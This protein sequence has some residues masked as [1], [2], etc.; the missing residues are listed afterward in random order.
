[1][2]SASP[3]FKSALGVSHRKV[4]TI[5]VNTPDG[6]EHELQWA[7]ASVSSSNSTGVRYSANVDVIPDP[8]VDLYSIISTPG[9]LFTIRHGIDFGDGL[10]ELLP[11][12]VYEAASGG[13]DIIDGSIGLSLVDQWQRVE[14]C[15]FSKPFSSGATG[16]GRGEIIRRVIADIT[17]GNNPGAIPG[18]E[19][20]IRDQGGTATLVGRVWDKDRT[21]FIKDMATDGELEYYFDASGVFVVR[22]QPIIDPAASVWTFQTGGA[23]NIITA[24]RERPFDRLYNRVVIRPTVEDQDWPAVVVDIT[25]TTH[26]RHKDKIGVVPYFYSSPTIVDENAAWSAANT[27]LQRVQGTTETLTISALGAPLEVGDVVTVTHQSTPSNPGFSAVHIVDG[28][29]YDLA[30]GLMNVKTRSNTL[31]ETEEEAA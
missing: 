15:R 4:T 29:D 7:S 8:G 30:S 21:Q 11:F 20:D 12:G 28:F 26:P 27:I 6:I 31:A 19:T 2:Q 9:A 1:M 13:I 10:T 18:A 23:G 22:K 25:D 5:T 3:L 17:T 14:R 16:T 24:E